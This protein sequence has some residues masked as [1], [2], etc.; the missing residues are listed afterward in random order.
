MA[1]LHP[2]HNS[3]LKRLID[4][5]FNYLPTRTIVIAS[6]STPSQFNWSALMQI[7]VISF[8][9]Q[10]WAIARQTAVTQCSHIL[11]PIVAFVTTLIKRSLAVNVFVIA[12]GTFGRAP[13][14]IGNLIILLMLQMRRSA[15]KFMWLL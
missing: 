4:Y 13:L 10:G 2:Y 14:S 6:Y 9:H 12:D 15:W 7:A 5:P 3:S 11:R 8:V 1:L